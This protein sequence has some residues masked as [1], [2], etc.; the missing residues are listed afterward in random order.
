MSDHS[1]VPAVEI[2][3]LSA[4][5]P[6]RTVTALAFDWTII[7]ATIAL[8]EWFENV[9]VYVIAVT[10]IAGRMHALGTDLGVP[11]PAQ[12]AVFRALH[13]HAHPS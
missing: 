6:W 4:L 2:A 9:L 12:T 10:V 11:T 13:L 7:V 8:S 5:R 1:L 3:K